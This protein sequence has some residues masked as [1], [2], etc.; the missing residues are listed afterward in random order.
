MLGSPLIWARVVR[1]QEDRKGPKQRIPRSLCPHLPVPVVACGVF[2]PHPR[3]QIRFLQPGSLTY[4]RFKAAGMG[5]AGELMQT[6]SWAPLAAFRWGNVAVGAHVV[7]VT[8]SCSLRG[9]RDWPA[10]LQ[11]LPGCSH[12]QP[13]ELG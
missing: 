2:H 6:H 13:A 7:A 12:H 4:P 5:K 3:E 1:S 10:T 8:G 9:P 11:V